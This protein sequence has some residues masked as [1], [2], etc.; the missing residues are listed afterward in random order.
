LFDQGAVILPYYP[1]ASHKTF[2][3]RHFFAKKISDFSAVQR[4]FS[5]S[6]ARKN[7]AQQIMEA[8]II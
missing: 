7:N 6:M 8:A 1:V 5:A 3:T 2:K 4:F